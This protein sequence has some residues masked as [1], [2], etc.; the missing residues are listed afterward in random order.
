MA[1]SPRSTTRGQV[2]P[3]SSYPAFGNSSLDQKLGNG[4][5]KDGDLEGGI[6][7]GFDW[8]DVV[9]EAGKWS[10][11]LAND[12]AKDD[13]TVD[14]TPRRCQKFKVSAGRPSASGPPRPAPAAR[15]SWT[16]GDW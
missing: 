3:Q 5:P 13:M 16:S 7:L 1:T 15:R 12:L 4:D 2:R 6:N 9:D 8:K 10:V 11:T 14:V